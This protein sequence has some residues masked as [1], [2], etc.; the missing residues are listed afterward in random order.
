MS[1][2]PETI[3]LN[4]IDRVFLIPETEDIHGS[5]FPVTIGRLTH[6]KSPI[7]KQQLLDA[8]VRL[9]DH[10]PQLRLR[11]RI[12][13]ETLKFEKIP[14]S[15]RLSYFESLIEEVEGD[16]EPDDVMADLISYNTMP[17]GSLYNFR[18]RNNEFYLK[19]HHVA[20]DGRLLESF[21]QAMMY[22]IFMPEKLD[23]LPYA[24]KKF[25]I[26]IQKVIWNNP[27]MGIAVLARF[28]WMIG[29]RFFKLVVAR[30][31]G[32]SAQQNANK[33]ADDSNAITS[34]TAMGFAT[35]VIEPE[36]FKRLKK[37][38]RQVV[39]GE[40]VSLN[41]ILNV[42]LALRLQKMGY[43]GQ[44]VTYTIPVDLRRYMP[45]DANFYPSNLS[46][47][48]RVTTNSN[49]PAKVC[50]QITAETTRAFYSFEPLIGMPWEWLTGLLPRAMYDRM[51]RNHRM[52]AKPDP[53]RFF[54]LS[55]VGALDRVH[56]DFNPYIEPLQY[57]TLAATDTP[58]LIIFG[59]M[60]GYGIWTASFNPKIISKEEVQQ[61]MNFN[62][63][64]YLV[65]GE[66]E[67]NSE[68]P[69]TEEAGKEALVT[70]AE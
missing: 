8:L 45:K 4:C 28:A 27:L 52:T 69:A 57:G 43:L 54:I 38:R 44:R 16:A 41:N 3:P 40:K 33:K 37:L 2:L 60:H 70:Q 50:Q 19:I 48:I 7:T 46:S 18:F 55:N 63:Q 62:D 17:L 12:N 1:I 35:A 22:A 30:I 68:T 59:S 42:E 21:Q 29:T 9:D 56:G 20:G 36:N 14:D 65:L 23:S 24:D 53:E 64:P 47:A 15:D 58:I 67:K 34:H 31:T 5:Y 66:D 49:D 32:G 51:H 39:E 25:W 10:F 26:P 61:L 13:V 11:Y 6:F